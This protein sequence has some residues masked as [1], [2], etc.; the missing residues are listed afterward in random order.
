MAPSIPPNF[1]F[2][3]TS[4]TF[5]VKDPEFNQASLTWIC[6]PLKNN[7]G[8]KLSV[9]R[10]HT[11]GLSCLAA[12]VRTGASPGGRLRQTA[13]PARVSRGCGLS[14]GRSQSKAACIS[15]AD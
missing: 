3:L 5:E 13:S 12:Q 10:V 1:P 14:E 4:A 8:K 2:P 15:E 6:A 7:T 9:L 11:Q